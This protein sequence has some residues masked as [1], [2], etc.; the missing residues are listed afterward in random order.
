MGEVIFTEDSYIKH[1]STFWVL[2]PLV[3]NDFNLLLPETPYTNVISLALCGWLKSNWIVLS[4]GGSEIR[5][6]VAF[7][8]GQ[9]LV[10]QM[11]NDILRSH[12]DVSSD[13]SYA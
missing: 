11:P 3:A 6:D 5:E 13:T 7:S 9:N 4:E 8:F 10:P 1:L 12:L 2:V